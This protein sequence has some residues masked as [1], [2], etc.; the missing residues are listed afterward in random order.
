MLILLAHEHYSI[1]VIFGYIVPMAMIRQLTDFADNRS[2]AA[3]GAG[4][5]IGVL[6]PCPTYF[7][8]DVDGRIPEEYDL[9][10]QLASFFATSGVEKEE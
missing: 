8:G 10:P 6:L 2:V 1:D 9:P 4:R 7:E 3:V 5:G